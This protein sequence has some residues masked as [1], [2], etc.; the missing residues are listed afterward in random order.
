M[1]HHSII[2]TEENSTLNNQ[3][4]ATLS[5]NNLAEIQSQQTQNALSDLAVSGE[6]ELNAIANA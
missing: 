2:Q 4:L 6:N 5:L 1:P 3:Y